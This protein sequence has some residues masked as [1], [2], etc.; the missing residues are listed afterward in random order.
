MKV[1]VIVGN[2]VLMAIGIAAIATG[3]YTKIQIS[4]N[5]LQASG[6]EAFNLA[7]IGLILI[8]F[9]IVFLGALG[10]WGAGKENRTY[11]GF[12]LFLTLIL[13]LA[14]FGLGVYGAIKFLNSNGTNATIYSVLD[15]Q[16]AKATAEERQTIENAFSCCGWTSLTDNPTSNCTFTQSC[17]EQVGYEIKKNV[18]LVIGSVLGFMA[19]QLLWLILSCCFYRAVGKVKREEHK[20]LLDEA[21]LVNRNF[22]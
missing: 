17:Q 22:R 2:L 5:D 4:N 3:I 20:K 15:Q 1:I 10:T 6:S 21:Y 9:A 13:V 11:I 14:Q 16:W 12:Y 19:I 7:P 18:V 8:G